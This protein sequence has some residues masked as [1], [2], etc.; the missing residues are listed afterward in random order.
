MSHHEHKR[1]HQKSVTFH[2]ITA[3]DTRTEDTDHSGKFLLE[4][5]EQ[6]GHKR[7]GYQLLK[8]EPELIRGAI[9]TILEAGSADVVVVNG[10]TGIARRDSTFEAIDSLLEKRIPGFGELFRYLSYEDIGAA[11][12]LSRATAG[13]ARKAIVISLPGSTAAVKLATEKLIMPEIG[14]M[15]GLVR[16]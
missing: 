11:A 16:E 3:S 6:N 4:T 10:G 15:V 1:K 12:M 7:T 5:F 2:V 14:H 9:E 8:D 13:V